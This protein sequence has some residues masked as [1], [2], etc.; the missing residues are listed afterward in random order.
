MIEEV[1]RFW[2]DRRHLARKTWSRE[3][4]VNETAIRDILDRHKSPRW[5][6]IEKLAAALDLDTLEFLRCEE[7]PGV[8]VVGRIGA[9]EAIYP[10]DDHVKGDGLEHIPAPPGL[11][12]SVA[13]DVRG[14]SMFPVYWD[15]DRVFMERMQD[16]VP[17]SAIG[18]E[19]V[20][21]VHEG[22]A[23]IKLVRR[24]ASKSLFDLFSYNAPTQEAQRLDWASPVLYVDRRAR[25][26]TKRAA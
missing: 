9:G 14:D 24:S 21:Q 20:V 2:M 25:L 11:E 19:C 8:P 10:I 1:I 7:R 18:Q 4:N 15:G 5:D 13:A 3:A 26:K 22:P 23:L 17:D 12:R 6:T 16:G